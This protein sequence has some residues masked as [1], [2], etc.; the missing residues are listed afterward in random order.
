MAKKLKTQSSKLKAKKKSVAETSDTSQIK[1]PK[2]FSEPQNM[3]EL[4]ASTGYAL[5]GVKKG[6]VVTGTISTVS[7]REVTIDIG[8]KTEG[9]V[10]DRELETYKD[11]LMKL[12]RGDEVTAQ[13][14]VAE[15]DRGQSVLSL[16]KSIFENQWQNLKKAQ[17]DGLSLDV[18]VK[19]S[20]RGGVLVD[21]SGLRG[22]IPQSQLESTFAKQLDK[23]ANRKIKVKVMEV[24]RDTNRLIFSQKA[25]SEEESLE[26]QK[27][28]L[29]N[30][31]VGDIVEAT[32]TGVVPFGAF[33][34]FKVTKDGK[35][36]DIEG[37]IHISEIAWEKVEDPIQY[38]TS[39]AKI[40]VKIVGIDEATGKLTLSIKQLLPDPW[41][42]VIDIFEKDMQVKGQVTRV[43]PYGVFVSL[44][45]GIEGLIHIS[46]IAPG[47][48]PKVGDE[49]TCNVE[50]VQPDKR[51]IS[52]S[53]TLTEKPIGYR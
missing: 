5:K 38:V 41:D 25:V 45:P 47:E 21:S 52:L 31:K 33:A 28:L 11:A 16:R 23:A 40:K 32:I 27:E 44:S 34:K 14:I 49:L 13:V 53:M 4:L 10:I 19:E 42:D 36:Q 39:G 18:I 9:V 29:V 17:T 30:V 2:K 43:T 46:K 37:L 1:N 8:G 7:P 6:D 12:K 51:K 22:Y 3:E 26:R 48:E 24:D 50:D 20:V 15:N 35:D